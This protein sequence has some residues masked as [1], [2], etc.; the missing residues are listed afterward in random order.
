MS[1]TVLPLVC[2]GYKM[3]C[4]D[5]ICSVLDFVFDMAAAHLPWLA[6]NGDTVTSK[7]GNI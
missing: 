7:G 1:V 6:I 4:S 2:E 3:G 5:Y